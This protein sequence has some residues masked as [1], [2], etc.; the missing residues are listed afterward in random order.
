VLLVAHGRTAAHEGQPDEREDDGAR[1]S[2]AFDARLIAISMY[3]VILA[4]SGS[5]S[6]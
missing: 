4:Q 3:L 6:A 1:H 5:R 2:A